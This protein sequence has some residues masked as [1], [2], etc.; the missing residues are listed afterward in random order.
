MAIESEVIIGKLQSEGIDEK[1]AAGISFE[2]EEALNAWVG[3]AK[4]F[5]TK[6]KAMSEYTADELK[7]MADKGE[8]KN[9]Q[10]LLD[11]IRTESSKK[12]EPEKKGDTNPELEALKAKLAEIQ[13]SI[14][15]STAQTALEKRDAVINAK[16]K[17]LEPFEVSLLKSS[18]KSDA[19][20]ADI[21]KTISD[22]RSL[23]VKR[24]L[25]GYATEQSSGKSG[26]PSDWSDATKKFVE[27]KQKR[28]NT[29]T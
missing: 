9:V 19:T 23:M 24:G 10:S 15:S 25:K 1:L 27:S 4:T 7:T 6:P 29:Q 14:E 20:E 8:L 16:T 22:Y 26:L 13:Q 17:G 2:T 11:K 3:T 12:V 28:D 5:V 21:D 18:I